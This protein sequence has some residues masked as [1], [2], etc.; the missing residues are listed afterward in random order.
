MSE[1]KQKSIVLDRIKEAYKLKSNAEL[2]RFLGVKPNTIS[3]WYARNSIDYDIVFSKCEG[4]NLDWLING[5][6]KSHITS[7][8][9]SLS[10][11]LALEEKE[12]FS[13]ITDDERDMRNIISSKG[14][15]AL[16]DRLVKHSKCEYAHDEYFELEVDVE[17]INI[18][19]QNYSLQ[20]KF[21]K[22]YDDFIDNKISYKELI[23]TF[24]KDSKVEIELLKILHPYK[25]II[26]EIRYKISSFNDLHDRLFSIDDDFFDDVQDENEKK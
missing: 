5:I 24:K 4:T 2:A 15:I 20:S 26:S 16:L 14:F 7:E 18:W 13:G 21:M 19:L 10:R 11:E 25:N 12:S 6:S 1:E 17:M 23:A 3:N 9:I 22:A 8:T